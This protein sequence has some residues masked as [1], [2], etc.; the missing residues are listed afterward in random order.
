[1]KRMN[2]LVYS[3]SE[4]YYSDREIYDKVHR[5]L[6]SITLSVQFKYEATLVC[7]VDLWTAL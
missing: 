6:Y 7:F 1:M 2:N 5:Q 4:A 3:L